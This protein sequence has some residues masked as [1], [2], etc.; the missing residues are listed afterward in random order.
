MVKY[1]LD[2]VVESTPTLWEK[3]QEFHQQLLFL[4]TT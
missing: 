3:D 4:V 2:R 1:W